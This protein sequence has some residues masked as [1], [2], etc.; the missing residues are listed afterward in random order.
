MRYIVVTFA[1]CLMV[2]SA[3]AGTYINNFD[4]GNLDNWTIFNFRGGVAEWE[5]EDGVLVCRRPLEPS[6]SLLYGEESWGAYD[7]E[8]DAKMVETFPNAEGFYA[9]ALDLRVSNI[10]NAGSISDIWCVVCKYGGAYIWAWRNGNPGA[11]SAVK[12]FNLQLD[13]WYHLKATT[14]GNNFEFYIDGELIASLSESQHPTGRV[15]LTVNGAVAHFDNLVITG[16][17]VPDS[18]NLT[19]ISASGKLATTWGQL[20]SK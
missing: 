8:C 5:I 19:A 13:R 18:S 1:L 4:G 16:D 10:G 20:R 11:K 7:I 9:I 2:T 17:D 15:G 12:A 6:S 3:Q 14:N